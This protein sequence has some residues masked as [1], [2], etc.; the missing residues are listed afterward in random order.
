MKPFFIHKQTPGGKF[1]GFTAKVEPTDNPR[2]VNVAVCFCSRKDNFVKA[3]GRN[4]AEQQTFN[5]INKRQLPDWLSKQYEHAWV[6]GNV[7]WFNN[8]EAWYYV[9][10]YVV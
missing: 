7:S 4:V 2:T 6:G 9:L 3:V 10:K 8:T 1:N 5:E